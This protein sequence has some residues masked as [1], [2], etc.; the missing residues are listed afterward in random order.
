[1]PESFSAPE[2]NLIESSAGYAVRVLGRTGIEYR[3]AGRVAIVDSEVLA[4][5]GRMA[6]YQRS[7]T[8]WEPPDGGV[9]SPDDQ[10]RIIGNIV[11]AFAWRG[12]EAQLI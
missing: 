5:P 12:Y 9:I 10:A 11:R 6:V 8:R 7:L 1:M 3:E 2:P 4:T